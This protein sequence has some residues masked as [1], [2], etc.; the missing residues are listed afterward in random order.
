[1]SAAANRAPHD[2]DI[3]I[4]AAARTPMG[5][6]RGAFA[7]VRGDHL[8]AAVLNGLIDRA[9][10]RADQ[11][12]EV[13]FGCV[14]QI[15]EQ[16]A[17][18]ARTSLLG[19]G[20]P[21][22]IPGL[23][24]DRKCGSSETAIHVAAGLIAAGSCNLVVA[25]GIESMT[26]VPMGSNRAI[27][28][29]PYGWMAMERFAV[30]HQ[31]EASERIADR[32]NLTR[33]DLDDFAIRSH[34]LAAQA[35]DAGAFDAEIVPVAIATIAERDAEPALATLAHDETIRRDTSRE[36]LGTLRTVFRENGRSTAGNS[37]QITDGASAVLIT[38]RGHARS[39]GLT[40]RAR[41]VAFTSVG[42]D[43]E[44]VLT[45]P[46]PA[47]RKALAMAGLGIDDMDLYEINEAFAPVPLAWLAELGGDAEK[48]NV[49]GGAIALGHPMG[50]SGTR[51]MT[52][53][54]HALERKGLRYGLQSMCCNGGIATATIIEREDGYAGH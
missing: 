35:A 51:I 5:R 12:D 29:E 16:S 23:T 7:G 19:A 27:H 31:G 52:T 42:A 18:V 44:L 21:E 40:P 6:F 48:L 25:G 50:A 28:G 4:V 24:I 17:N 33:A 2:D 10:I 20:W 13:V 47:S 11:V 3:V 41:L 32:W 53:L 9:G 54:I 14:T 37:S 45:G 39:L 22:T 1:M 8:G 15:G 46:I 36:K 38:T 49:H 26:R 43:P 30:P 34:A